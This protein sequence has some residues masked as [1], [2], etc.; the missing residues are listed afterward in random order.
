MVRYLY[1][2]KAEPKDHWNEVDAFLQRCDRNDQ[3]RKPKYDTADEAPGK[4]HQKI[5]QSEPGN[6]SDS[7]R[8][9]MTSRGTDAGA[10]VG[11]SSTGRMTTVKRERLC[12][13]QSD[14]LSLLACGE[15]R[16][17]SMSTSYRL[18]RS[19]QPVTSLS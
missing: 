18:R 8:Q 1:C 10:A 13:P 5:N 12:C 9:E 19:L 15:G 6:I 2:R 16:G 11:L 4:I 7:Y 17:Q 14:F 3:I